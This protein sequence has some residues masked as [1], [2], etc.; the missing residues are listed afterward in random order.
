MLFIGLYNH[1][2]FFAYLA[3]FPFLCKRAHHL[4][5]SYRLLL[6]L[7]IGTIFQSRGLFSVICSRSTHVLAQNVLIGV[8]FV[9]FG[10]SY[11]GEILFCYC[12]CCMPMKQN[13]A[14]LT[15]RSTNCSDFILIFLAYFAKQSTEASI[16]DRTMVKE[17]NF[18]NVYLLKKDKNGSFLQVM[19]ILF[20]FWA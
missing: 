7:G 20:S 18:L 10:C 4:T 2:K 14:S 12:I 5:N 13:H 11:T 1:Y 17:G 9:P 15:L 19:M 3:M 16:G 6:F 8:H